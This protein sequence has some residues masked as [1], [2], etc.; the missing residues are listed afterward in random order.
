MVFVEKRY[1]AK[2]HPLHINY[3]IHWPL[4]TC[5]ISKHILEVID[6]FQTYCT[7]LFPWCSQLKNRRT[8]AS[9]KLAH[10]GGWGARSWPVVFFINSAAMVDARGRPDLVAGYG[11][12]VHCWRP[13]IY[14]QNKEQE[15]KPCFLIIVFFFQCIV[16]DFVSCSFTSYPF[17]FHLTKFTNKHYNWCPPLF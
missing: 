11:W 8:H 12:L 5:V 17:I 16:C 2:P 15:W 14:C 4:L 10:R 1:V 3:A 9:H 13:Y 7:F 6:V